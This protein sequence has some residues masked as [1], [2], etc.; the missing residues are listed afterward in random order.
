[1]DEIGAF[2]EKTHLSQ[3][4]DRVEKGETVTITRRGKPVAKLTPLDE[5]PVEY[6]PGD[7]RHPRAKAIAAA[8]RIIERTSKMK[9]TG[10]TWKD[11]KAFRDEGRKY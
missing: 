6:A 3:L 10:L 9:P 4:L 2:E 5:A 11:W 1:M 8:E 7:P